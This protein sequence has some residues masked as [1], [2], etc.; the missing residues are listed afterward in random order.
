MSEKANKKFA[1]IYDKHIDQIY[2][3]VFIKTGS[4][5]TAEDLTSQV[6]VKGWRKFK[7]QGNDIKNVSAYLY[8]IARA[9]IANFYRDAAKFQIVSTGAVE[10]QDNQDDLEMTQEI[11]FMGQDM[12][13]ALRTIEEDLQN[14][15][16]WHYVEGL[17]FK[18]ISKFLNR[19]EGTVRVMAHRAL[20]ELR[21]KLADPT[22]GQSQEADSGEL[23]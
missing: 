3:F 8:Q 19:P 10:I 9:E 12:Q 15:L 14:I 6:F 1:K 4:K 13:K 5:E 22:F 17:A 18:E 7:A 16:I 23:L 11:N 20:K 2:R 21:E